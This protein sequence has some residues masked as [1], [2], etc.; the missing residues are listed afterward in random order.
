MVSSIGVYTLNSVSAKREEVQESEVQKFLDDELQ[1]LREFRK[2]VLKQKLT[3]KL[4][5]DGVKLP[6]EP[7]K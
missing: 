7:P 4:E 5:L 2:A 1:V 3:P 6:G